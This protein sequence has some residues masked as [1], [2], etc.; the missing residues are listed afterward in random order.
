MTTT[1]LWEQS[2]STS[3]DKL[4]KGSIHI[5]YDCDTDERGSMA[6]VVRI[7]K[8]R[9]SSTSCFFTTTTGRC[10]TIHQR[11]TTILQS[12]GRTCRSEW[13]FHHFHPSLM[14]KRARIGQAIELMGACMGP[15]LGTVG[16]MVGARAF[17]RLFFCC[18][19][20]SSIFNLQSSV[21]SLQSSGTL[22]SF[23]P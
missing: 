12:P 3:Q 22:L 23:C 13:L 5:A 2:H 9:S 8:R 15:S 16:S 14:L 1:K 4:D 20:Q 17:P 18:R 19:M 6:R 11:A 21:F 10:C 7:A